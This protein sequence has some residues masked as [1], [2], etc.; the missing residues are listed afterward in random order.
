MFYEEEW[1]FSLTGNNM[2]TTSARQL[3]VIRFHRFIIDL[4][5]EHSHPL[6]LIAN[7]DETLLTFDMAQTI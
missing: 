2:S 3:R 7:M 1:S 6:H 4:H 5:K